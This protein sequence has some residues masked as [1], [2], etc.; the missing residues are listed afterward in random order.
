MITRPFA[1]NFSLKTG[2]SV[3]RPTAHGGIW[4]FLGTSQNCC[5][6]NENLWLSVRWSLKIIQCNWD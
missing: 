5:G 6:T 2:R 3:Q 4:W 1:H